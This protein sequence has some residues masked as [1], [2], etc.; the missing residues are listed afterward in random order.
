MANIK[1]NPE[2]ND[3]QRSHFADDQE[4]KAKV[5]D[6]IEEQLEKSS[7]KAF[8]SEGFKSRMDTAMKKDDETHWNR[9]EG[10][11][12]WNRG[13]YGDGSTYGMGSKKGEVNV[14]VNRV[15]GS[16]STNGFFEKNLS[17][18]GKKMVVEIHVDVDAESKT[19]DMTY[20]TTEVSFFRGHHDKKGPFMID[21]KCVCKLDDMSKFKKELKEKFD[22]YA[23]REANYFIKT[24]L[25]I[26]DRVEKSINSMVENNMS[27]LSLKDILSGDYDEALNKIM[28]SVKKEEKEK[29]EPNHR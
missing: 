2:K 21:E 20:K 11:Q 13:V 29:V 9:G 18:G 10:E 4:L 27:K 15:K 3:E 24:K 26:E 6:A 14:T 25:G 17:F 23:E 19:M 8:D 22:D 7:E 5:Y 16:A 1:N 12:G 28:E